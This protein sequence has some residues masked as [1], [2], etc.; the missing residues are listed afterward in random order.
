MHPIDEAE[1]AG[2]QFAIGVRQRVVR[3]QVRSSK[4]AE[5]KDAAWVPS[6]VRHSICSS[7]LHKCGLCATARSVC[8]LSSCPGCPRSAWEALKWMVLCSTCTQRCRQ[9]GGTPN[10]NTYANFQCTTLQ[11]PKSVCTRV[12]AGANSAFSIADSTLPDMGDGATGAGVLS[13]SSHSPSPCCL[14]SGSVPPV[15][16][17]DPQT[18]TLTC[19]DVLKS[20]PCALRCKQTDQAASCV[21]G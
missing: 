18:M 1:E 5:V 3:Y 14:V 9:G 21:D 17:A 19:S 13:S 11:R 10:G 4:K 6:L 16:Q 7:L 20:M 8:V 2:V 12:T 15:L